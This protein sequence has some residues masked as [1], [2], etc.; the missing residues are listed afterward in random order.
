MTNGETIPKATEKTLPV[1]TRKD[2]IKTVSFV[3]KKYQENLVTK[4]LGHVV[5]YSDVITSTQTVFDGLVFF[6]FYAKISNQAKKQ[7]NIIN[8]NM[9]HYCYSHQPS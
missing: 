2:N 8:N 6:L 4:V 3:W 9:N 1:V 7:D 5:F